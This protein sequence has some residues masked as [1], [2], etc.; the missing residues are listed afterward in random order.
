MHGFRSGALQDLV[1]GLGKDVAKR[2]CALPVKTA[3]NH[4]AVAEDAEV[5]PQTVTE[6][7]VSPVL[8][9]QIRPVE[10]VAMLEKE[11][12]LDADALGLFLPV[13]GEACLR[14]IQGEMLR[15]SS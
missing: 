8:G 4:R 3:G 15:P 7:G 12:V 11:L 6:D 5:I 9:L 1:H 10:P 2:N 14:Q 13:P